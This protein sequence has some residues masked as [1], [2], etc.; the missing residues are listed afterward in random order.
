M[1]TFLRNQGQFILQKERYAFFLTAL[2]VFL[3]FTAW[4]SVAVVGLVTL[5]KGHQ[6]GLRVLLVGLVAALVVSWIVYAAPYA[7]ASLMLTFI[8]CYA[9]ALLLRL[10]A[11]WNAVV[12]LLMLVGLAAIAFVHWFAPAYIL[13]QFDVLMSVLKKINPDSSVVQFLGDQ[14]GKHKLVWANYTMGIRVFSVICSVL[15]SLIVARYVQSLLFY[16]NGLRNEMLTF[17]ANPVGVLLMA[18]TIVGAYYNNTLALGCVPVLVVYLVVAGMSLTFYM[19]SQK[20]GILILLLLIV[21]LIIVPYVMLPFYVI[22]GS[23]DSL[24]NFRVLLPVKAED[25]KTRG[26]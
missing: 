1:N 22:L 24:F 19:M 20:N 9:A 4:I 17:R 18:L 23:L 13:N 25:T 26:E 16:P 8:T 6:D 14:M 11:S 5:R 2:L 7:I 10:T 21:P 12:F 15:S 3:P